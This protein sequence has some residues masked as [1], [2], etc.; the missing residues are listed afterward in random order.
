MK[1]DPSVLNQLANFGVAPLDSIKGAKQAIASKKS[2]KA[3]N[4]QDAETLQNAGYVW[5]SNDNTYNKGDRKIYA[6]PNIFLWTWANAIG[7]AVK[8]GDNLSK[9]LSG[10]E[11][12]PQGKETHFISK[13]NEM[14]GQTSAPID[15]MSLT[16]D[17]EPLE[18]PPGPVPDRSMVGTPPSE[19]DTI[20]AQAKKEA[21]PNQ[22]L[23]PDK[24]I[25]LYQKAK[26]FKD[27]D[28][29]GYTKLM[30][31]IKTLRTLTGE[32][33]KR[34][35]L[36]KL[37]QEI[38]R[39]VVRE[40]NQGKLKEMTTTAAVSPVTGPKAFKKKTEEETIEEMTTTSAVSG[41]NV[42]GAFTNKMNRKDRIEV[43]GYK[44]TP[45]GNREYN[46]PGDRKL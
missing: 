24:I 9:W 14:T 16:G 8:S 2:T 26:A 28:P 13:Y 21:G 6:F 29:E 38:V 35:H 5:S 43:L 37:I 32:S 3:N 10:D 25:D 15:R 20:I 42:P 34:S 18:Y 12:Y 7:R 41:Y 46:R 39:R 45:E 33:I 19:V 22:R 23:H 17:P 44:M 30:T 40:I 27:S 11:K 36:N 4:P 31:F 1:I